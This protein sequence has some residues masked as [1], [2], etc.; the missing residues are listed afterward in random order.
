[1]DERTEA[2]RAY[3]RA[4]SARW[5]AANRDKKREWDRRYYEANRGRISERD[6]SYRQAHQEQH[7][8]TSRRYR[9]T[10]AE[11]L[12][13]AKAAYYLANRERLQERYRAN[14]AKR[15][16]VPHEPWATPGILARDGWQ[17]QLDVCKCPT[18]RAID[19]AITT[20]SQWQGTVDHIIPITKGGP[21]T[22]TNLQAAH[23]ACNTSKGDR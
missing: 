10:N 21:D 13:A 20:R 2:Q 9:Q 15:Y 6:R 8:E 23:R 3:S 4:S 11:T 12:K 16:G 22:P 7:R 14:R 17:C 19:P 5:A 18:G 1:M